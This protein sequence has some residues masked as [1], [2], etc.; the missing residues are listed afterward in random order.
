MGRRYYPVYSDRFNRFF[1]G[2]Q[3]RS[4]EGHKDAGFHYLTAITKPQIEALL[5][6]EV[7]QLSMFDEDLVEV[8]TEEVRYI[9]RRNPQR[10]EELAAVRQS[11]RERLDNYLAQKN[12]Y[13][14]DHPRAKVETAL[15]NAQAKVN[16]LKVQA[17]AK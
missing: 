12:A 15:K 3:T 9:V 13:L 17:W 14:A 10:A 6:T 1:L 4:P 2:C 7:L 11:K 8:T 16:Q 5:K